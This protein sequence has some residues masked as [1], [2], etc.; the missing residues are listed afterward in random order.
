MPERNDVNVNLNL[1][2]SQGQD[3]LESKLDP[4]SELMRA[5]TKRIEA[6]LDLKRKS[7]Q[8]EEWNVGKFKPLEAEL[9]TYEAGV[10]RNPDCYLEF[11]VECVK[12]ETRYGIYRRFLTFES[13][14]AKFAE[15]MREEEELRKNETIRTAAERKSYEA[16]QL[17]LQSI[18]NKLDEIRNFQNHYLKC[19]LDA[20]TRKRRTRFL[21]REVLP[22]AGLGLL[23]GV[24]ALFGKAKYEKHLDVA[25]AV[26]KKFSVG[27]KEPGKDFA[28]E[29]ETTKNEFINYVSSLLE[30]QEQFKKHRDAPVID[31]ILFGFVHGISDIFWDYDPGLNGVVHKITTEM[32]NPPHVSGFLTTYDY[33]RIKREY[34]AVITSGELRQAKREQSKYETLVKEYLDSQDF[35]DR[36]LSHIK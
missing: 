23:F 32:D 11:I 1:N 15:L 8:L 21:I 27:Q 29:D 13:I 5:E 24:I 2:L 20:N 4:E 19:K 28:F 25:Y 3:K 22:A 35:R 18:G 30:S 12:G 9:R 26:E 6:E 34:K 10:K 36:M 14:E 31:K 33:E 17:K 16:R 7:A